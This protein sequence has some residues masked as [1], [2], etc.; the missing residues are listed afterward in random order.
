MLHAAASSKEIWGPIERKDE[1]KGISG[2]PGG[3]WGAA[4]LSLKREKLPQLPQ[5]YFLQP[6]H[7]ERHF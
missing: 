1:K 2:T 5:L 4:V 7:V 6:D 3:F